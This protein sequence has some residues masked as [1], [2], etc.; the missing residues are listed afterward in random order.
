VTHAGVISQIVGYIEGENPA[1]WE[2]FRPRN[3]TTTQ[4]EWREGNLRL[5]RFDD[6]GRANL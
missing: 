3:A 6:L 5:A 1:R 2:S 4:V